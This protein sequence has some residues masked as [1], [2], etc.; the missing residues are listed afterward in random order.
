MQTS[1]GEPLQQSLPQ[2]PEHF[3]LAHY[4]NTTTCE[5][6]REPSPRLFFQE[7]SLEFVDVTNPRAWAL[8]YHACTDSTW[9]TYITL[10]TPP[11]VLGPLDTFVWWYNPCNTTETL[12]YNIS[13]APDSA[14][15]FLAATAYD[16]ELESS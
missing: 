1:C 15:F 9:E 12:S 10:F 2:T 7:L 3:A 4:G 16:C 6:V 5:Q 13:R 8:P 11:L 14:C